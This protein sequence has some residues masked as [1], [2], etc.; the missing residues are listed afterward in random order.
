[1]QQEITSLDDSVGKQTPE[2]KEF[3]SVV[4]KI[5]ETND[6]NMNESFDIIVNYIT[7]HNNRDTV[8]YFYKLVSYCMEVRP[9]NAKIFGDLL[10]SLF[11]KYGREEVFRT[12]TGSKRFMS[13][14]AIHKMIDK[15]KIVT[16]IPDEE[17]LFRFYEPDT[18]GSF[19]QDDDIDSFQDLVAKT[20]E[21]KYNQTFLITPGTP[22]YCIIQ[23]KYAPKNVSLLSLSAFYGAI[24]IFKYLTLNKVEYSTIDTLFAVAGGN[25]EIIHL[26]EHKNVKFDT[27]CFKLASQYHRNDLFEWLRINY[28]GKTIQKYDKETETRP[29]PPQSAAVANFNPAIFVFTVENMWWPDLNA[30]YEAVTVNDLVSFNLLVTKQKMF[31]VFNE[32]VLSLAC[33]NGSYDI[34]DILL[35]EIK[36][37]T[38]KQVLINACKFN[39]LEIVQKLIDHGAKVQN[40]DNMSLDIAIRNNNIPLISLLLQNGAKVTVF[41]RRTLKKIDNKEILELL[42]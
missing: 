22:P 25:F 30:V 24:K 28:M 35:K 6:S 9:L 8:S 41:E 12:V 4:D 40:D 36:T 13:F 29:F 33:L 19:I 32:K 37:F 2:M 11:S 20:I 21:F 10:C 26:L 17:K 27:F 23:S 18:I 7:N 1:M 39:S 15:E 3:I 14:L 42:K 5:F 38:N 16:E 31:P 34:I